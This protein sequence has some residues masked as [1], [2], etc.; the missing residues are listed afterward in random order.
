LELITNLQQIITI[1]WSNTSD[2]WLITAAKEKSASIWDT[3]T[4][5]CALK[6]DRHADTLQSAIFTHDDTK[7]VTLGID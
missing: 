7:V 5:A 1:N 4:G 3:T 2:K 6:L